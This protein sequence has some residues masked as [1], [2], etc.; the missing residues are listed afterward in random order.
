MGDHSVPDRLA[1]ELASMSLFAGLTEEQLEDVAGTVFERRVKQGK[2]VLK[3][4]QWGHEFLLVL[5]GELEVRRDGQVV[6]TA[7]PGSY[8]GELAVL[9]DVRRNATVVATMPS[10][11]GAI[12]TSLF[13]PLLSAI[14]VLADRIVANA[15]RYES[16]TD[17]T[18]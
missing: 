7:G 14:P 17:R 18:P 15:T 3:Q 10:V 6:A 1:D 9:D 12:E 16:P 8:L 5:E 2:T 11:V 4:G 13:V